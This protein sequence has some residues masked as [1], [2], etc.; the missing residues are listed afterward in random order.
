VLLLAE[1]RDYEA[2]RRAIAL[3]PQDRMTANPFAAASDL[4]SKRLAY[5]AFVHFR[6]I[7]EPATARQA[8]PVNRRLAF[9]YQRYS[10]LLNTL[11]FD[12]QDRID[13]C[14]DR[15]PKVRLHSYQ[16]IRTFGLSKRHTILLAFPRAAGGGDLMSRRHAW[17]EIHVREFGLEI[18][19]LA[20][21]FALPLEELTLDPV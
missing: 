6:L 4:A 8:D 13:L 14:T 21:R 17:L 20:F 18:G 7:I 15:V 5:A 9:G 3:A 16:T 10:A 1:Y 11:L 2:K 12:M 19:D